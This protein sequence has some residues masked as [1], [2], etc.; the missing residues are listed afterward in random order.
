MARY[1]KIALEDSFSIESTQTQ[2]PL[3]AS[4]PKA[5]QSAYDSTAAGSRQ[6]PN[7]RKFIQHYKDITFDTL[8]ERH[9][10]FNFELVL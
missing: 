3:L 4:I 5:Q 7:Q 10:N 9:D 6:N 8:K 2:P 1:H